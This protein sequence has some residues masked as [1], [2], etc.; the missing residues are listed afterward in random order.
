MHQ[1]TCR[2]FIRSLCDIVEEQGMFIE[3]KRQETEKSLRTACVLKSKEALM[4]VHLLSYK[5]KIKKGIVNTEEEIQR[6]SKKSLDLK[7]IIDKSINK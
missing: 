6:L 3:I 2:Y 4:F 7:N 5:P 1:F